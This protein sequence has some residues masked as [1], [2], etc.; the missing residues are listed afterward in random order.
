MRKRGQ[1]LATRFFL[2]AL[3][4][5]AA[6][7]G[8]ARAQHAVGVPANGFSA[9]A[10]AKSETSAAD[11]DV[12]HVP[13]GQRRRVDTQHATNATASRAALSGRGGAT[14]SSEDKRSARG[15]G[16][17]AKLAT[18]DDAWLDAGER[19]DADAD[20]RAIAGLAEDA[21]SEL[22]TVDEEPAPSAFD[23]GPDELARLLARYANEPSAAQVVAAA[24]H[25]QQRDPARFAQLASRAR[26][27]GLLP[28]LDLG[29]RRGRGIDLRSTTTGELG[30]GTTADDLTLFATLRFDL[31]QL[32]M[33]NAEL[34]IARE[35]R[36]ARAAQNQLVRQ[37][38]R[39]YFIRRRLLLERD[40]RGRSDL[41]H[42]LRIAEAEALL[43]IFT[44]GTFR[45]MMN[46]SHGQPAQAPTL[47]GSG[48]R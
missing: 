36:Y 30:S 15:D 2:G 45:R 28:H 26:L 9:S 21:R 11:S 14:R 6:H 23:L 10:G 29:V 3:S 7:L 37:V 1:L 18:G 25:A 22:E 47:P 35:E 48:R 34:S 4:L 16:P 5:C 40:W 17:R 31:G 32:L 19:G 44:D 39:L 20:A 42:E 13:R 12:S 24:L 27:R 33:A 38:V 46:T 8:T 41:S 43:D